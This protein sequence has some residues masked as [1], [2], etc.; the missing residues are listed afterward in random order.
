MD[1]DSWVGT[2]FVSKC[3][4]CATP[5]GL[6]W[7]LLGILE[8]AF[9]TS[10]FVVGVSAKPVQLDKAFP[11]CSVMISLMT[12]SVNNIYFYLII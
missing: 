8:M 4:G 10:A 5:L 3:V 1:S 11:C 9:S 7:N 2:P 6:K 12:L